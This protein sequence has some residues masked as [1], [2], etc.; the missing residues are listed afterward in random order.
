MQCVGP[1]VFLGRWLHHQPSRNPVSVSAGDRGAVVKAEDPDQSQTDIETRRQIA[2]PRSGTFH[3]HGPAAAGMAAVAAGLVIGGRPSC[4]FDSTWE[5]IWASDALH[6]H[7]A[8]QPPGLLLPTAH[9]ASLL[10]GA[11]LRT[12]TGPTSQMAW[13]A[14]VEVCFAFALAGVFVLAFRLAGTAVASA[15]VIAF[16]SLPAVGAAV[17]AGTVDVIFA[18]TVVWALVLASD[19]PAVAVECAFVAALARPEGW[20]ALLAIVVWR[21]PGGARLKLS[22]WGTVALL[23]APTMWALVGVG[24]FHDPLAAFHVTV[25]N[26]ST[27]GVSGGVIPTIRTVA[28]TAQLLN[29]A[30]VAALAAWVLRGKRDDRGGRVIAAAWA[31][32]A[33]SVVLIGVL[34]AQTQPR[35]L[36]GELGLGLPQAFGLLAMVSRGVRGMRIA[37]IALLILAVTQTTVASQARTRLATAEARQRHVLTS[38][39]NVLAHDRSCNALTV[40]PTTDASAVILG[41]RRPVSVTTTTFRDQCRLVATS[42]VAL[43]GAGWGLVPLRLTREVVPPSTQVLARNRDWTLY[44]G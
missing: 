27:Q 43:T 38:L 4:G 32:M 15:A 12:A 25:S 40:G 41:A 37:T 14:T 1:R 29:V 42:D 39:A 11:I 19:R 30:L 20:L 24:L 33:L 7:R 31:S 21:V 36:I 28:G 10:L 6:A 16:A 8:T 3:A 13:A 9:P 2:D 26:A 17:G 23:A 22:G 5:L 34:G 44:V 35:Y 18:A